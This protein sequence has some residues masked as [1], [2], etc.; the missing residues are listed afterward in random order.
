MSPGTPSVIVSLIIF[1]AFS[2]W[3]IHS[4]GWA[5]YIAFSIICALFWGVYFGLQW[6]AERIFA[7]RGGR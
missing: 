2:A 7:K 3:M 6:L 1:I 4:H 5:Y